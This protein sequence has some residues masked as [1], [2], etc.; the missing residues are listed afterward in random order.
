MSSASDISAFINTVRDLCGVGIC[1]YD[2]SEFFNYN[3]LGVK[4]NR[5]HYCAFCEAVRALP[6]GHAQCEASDRQQAVTLALQY[7]EPF[8]FECHMGIKELVVPLLREEKLLGILFVGQCRIRGDNGAPAAEK[9]ALRLGGDPA[10]LRV[11]YD[12]L[13]LADR[14]DLLRTG[15]ILLQYFDSMILNRELL[16]PQADSPGPDVDTAAAMRDY[17]QSHGCYNITP[18]SVANGFFLN[19][20]Y[21]SRCFSRRFG[22]TLGEYICRVRMERARLLLRSTTA[23]IHSI[24]LNVGYP[25]SN[26][27]SRLFKKH[28]GMTP[29]QYRARCRQNP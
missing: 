29:Q 15:R 13:P 24:A 16:T 4:N 14:D 26:Y 12:A 20:S 5:G 3:K 11:L 19:P 23:P 27:F 25:E 18:G 17:I 2:L 6:G 1:Y 8:F 10:Q 9:G 28:T 7:R 21:A 22:C